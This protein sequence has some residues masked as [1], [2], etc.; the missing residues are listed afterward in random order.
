MPS[1][2]CA[3]AK[4]YT[5]TIFNAPQDG[6]IVG[7]KAVINK[8]QSESMSCDTSRSLQSN[9][10]CYKDAGTYYR[11]LFMVEIMKVTNSANYQGFTIYPT[12]DTPGYAYSSSAWLLSC[13]RGCTQRHYYMGAPI[14]QDPRNDSVIW[15]GGS[16]D[17]TTNDQF[18]MQCGEGCCVTSTSDNSGIAC[19]QIYFLYD[20]MFILITDNH[21]FLFVMSYISQL[22]THYFILTQYIQ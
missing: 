8:D 10:G 1:N 11:K 13:S 4:T 9:W 18:M 15:T 19:A 16:Y 21:R 3:Y 2:A 17:V 6:T 12:D 20:G 5:A 22:M 14:R 7:V